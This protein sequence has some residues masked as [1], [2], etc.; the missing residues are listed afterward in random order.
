[1]RDLL[2]LWAVIPRKNCKEE[3]RERKKMNDQ[4]GPRVKISVKQIVEGTQEQLAEQFHTLL[5][6]FK[7]HFF[8]IRLLP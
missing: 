5:S 8:N 7:M 1:M 4:E 6:K 2:K 3:K